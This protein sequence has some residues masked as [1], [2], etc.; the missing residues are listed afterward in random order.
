MQ[1]VLTATLSCLYYVLGDFYMSTDTLL[2]NV[3]LVF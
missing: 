1:V 2:Q 3:L